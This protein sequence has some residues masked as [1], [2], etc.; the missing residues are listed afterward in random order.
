MGGRRR[1]ATGWQ[2]ARR[3]TGRQI[4]GSGP[5]PRLYWAFDLLPFGAPPIRRPSGMG[6]AA[7][8]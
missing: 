5:F 4:E 1:T 8:E 6:R 3:T 7:T 2:I